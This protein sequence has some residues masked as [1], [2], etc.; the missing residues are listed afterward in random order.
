MPWSVQAS[1]CCSSR[2]RASPWWPKHLGEEALE[3]AFDQIPDVI[4]TDLSMQGMRG[5]AVVEA[6]A[7]R[8][9]RRAS[10]CCRWS[11]SRPTSVE[12][13]KRVPVGTC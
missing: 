3:I 11:T 1:D 8:Y 10:S 5:A 2:S 6:F 13:S 12:R 9:P 4:V 7:E